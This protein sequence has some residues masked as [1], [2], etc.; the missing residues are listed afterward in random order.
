LSHT[1]LTS[2]RR[3]ERE[4]AILKTLGF[5]RRQVA[6]VVAWQATTF[7]ASAALIGVPIGIAVGRWTWHALAG[8][9]GVDPSVA[10][11]LIIPVMV[12]AAVVF[13]N[14]LALV[15]AR[16]A[17]RTRVAQVLRSE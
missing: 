14:L 7:A 8:Q 17:T 5:V 2:I 12:P 11:P 6:G 10:Y 13:A 3:R 4:F 9:A 1:L 16:L 15:P